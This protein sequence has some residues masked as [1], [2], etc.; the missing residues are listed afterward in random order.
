M[1]SNSIKISLL[2]L[3]VVL[4]IFTSCKKDRENN[5]TNSNSNNVTTIDKLV[6]NSNFNFKTTNEV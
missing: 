1:K 5:L 6:V 2:F 4:G 3:T